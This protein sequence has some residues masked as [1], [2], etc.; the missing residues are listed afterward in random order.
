MGMR[1]MI[2]YLGSKYRLSGRLPAPLLGLPVVEPFAG[3]AAYS[4]RHAPL[5]AR[6]YDVD[7]HVFGAWSWLLTGD[8]EELPDAIHY[9]QK[10]ADF[11]VSPGA[12]QFLAMR[13]NIGSNGRAKQVS[14]NGAIDYRGTKARVIAQQKMLGA[15]T[16]TQASYAECPDIEATWFIDPPYYGVRSY[17]HDFRGIDFDHLREWILARR[18]LVIVTVGADDDWWPY[19]EKITRSSG[20]TSRG[21]NKRFVERVWAR[22]YG[23]VLKLGEQVV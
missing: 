21:P 12:R 5:T 20:T 17:K 3:S 11:K 18:G 15:W 19:G 10:I 4:V 22:R 23:D 8:A 16:I 13:A 2:T 14:K 1:P 6:L 9:G 7:E